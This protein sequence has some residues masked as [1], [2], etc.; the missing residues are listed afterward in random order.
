LRVADDAQVDRPVG[1]DGVGLE[2]DLRDP[3]AGRDQ[4]PVAR[5]L[6]VERRAEAHHHVGLAQQPR[7]DR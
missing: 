2:V 3:R 7:G 5:R 6:L 1:A 4:R